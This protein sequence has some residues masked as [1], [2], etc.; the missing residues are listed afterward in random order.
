MSNRSG[1]F[2]LQ[3]GGVCIGL[4][5][6]INFHYDAYFTVTGF[7][8]FYEIILWYWRIPNCFRFVNKLTIMMRNWKH[9]V[10]L[11]S[12]VISGFTLVSLYWIK[13]TSINLDTD[14]KSCFCMQVVEGYG[15]TEC[16]AIATLQHLADPGTGGYTCRNCNCRSC[17]WPVSD[18]S[19]YPL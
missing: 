7:W 12:I 6:N 5:G 8:N 1:E 14:A 4:L 18:L 3:V 11:I 2:D 13:T 16:H 9:S 19:I 15:Q 10:H 17:Q